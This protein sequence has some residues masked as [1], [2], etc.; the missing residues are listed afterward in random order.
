MYFSFNGSIPQSEVGWFSTN[1]LN[2]NIYF[3]SVLVLS[4]GRESRGNCVESLFILQTFRFRLLFTAEK[5]T[6]WF[7]ISGLVDLQPGERTTY[8]S[9]LAKM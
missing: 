3:V 4:M 8:L 2:K 5:K 9:A 6:F 1:L 7:P